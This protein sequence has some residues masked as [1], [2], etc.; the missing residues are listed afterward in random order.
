MNNNTDNLIKESAS[1][2]F[3]KEFST[4]T[5]FLFFPLISEIIIDWVYK[6]ITPLHFGLIFFLFLQTYLIINIKNKT[7]YKIFLLNLLAPWFYLTIEFFELGM[8]FFDEWLYIFYSIFII[9]NALLNWLVYFFSWKN[10]NNIIPII[11]MWDIILKICLLPIFYFLLNVE[12][13]FTAWLYSFYLWDHDHLNLF[14][15]ITFVYLSL[16]FWISVYIEEKRKNVFNNLLSILHKYSSWIVDSKDIINSLEKGA[17]DMSCKKTYK[18]VIFM[19]IRW[20]TSWSENNKPEQ[21]TEML[22]WFY[23]VA[24]ELIKKYKTWAINK[25]VADEI[26]FVFDDLDDAIDFSLELKDLE[27]KYLDKFWLKIGFWINA[28]VLIFWWIWGDTKKEQTVIWD[29]VNVAARLE[30]WVNMIKIPKHILPN[31][32]ISKDLWNLSLKW[33]AD[34]M[35]IVEVISKK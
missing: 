25:Y 12:S 6:I 15:F 19:D 26:V 8:N 33:K 1:F 9:F 3:F 23:R 11:K 30:W 31:R 17:V 27:I 24:E 20:F 2:K 28:W 7:F 22:N 16:I 21:V 5:A 29:V 18:S 34:E 32:Y 14:L 4:N 10:K 13:W 35:S